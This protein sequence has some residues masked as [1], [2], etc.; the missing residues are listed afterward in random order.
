MPT[1]LW[2]FLILIGIVVIVFAIFKRPLY[3]AML[4]SFVCLLAS[5]GM[6]NEAPHYLLSSAQNSL[7]FTIVMFLVFSSILKETGVIQDCIDIIMALVGRIPGG[8]GVVAIVSS[9]FMGAMS[10]SG[11]GNVAATGSVTI[12]LMKKAGYPAEFAAGIAM[13]G[14]CLGPVIPPSATIIAAFS[15]LSVVDGLEGF[16]FSSFW[17]VMYSVSLVFILHRL[18]QFYIMYAAL[19]IK[20]ADASELP[21]LKESW[22]R[23]W[24]SF[25]LVVVIMLPFALDNFFGDWFASVIG[26]TAADYLSDSVLVFT[27]AI[28]SAYSLLVSHKRRRRSLGELAKAVSSDMKS[29]VSMCMVLFFAYAISELLTD[30]GTITAA[31][32]F[33][34]SLNLSFGGMTFVL[35]VVMT[36][37]GMFMSGTSLIPLLGPVYVSILSGYGADPIVIA[38]IIPVLFVSLGQMTPPFALA[39]MAA[40]GIAQS[41]FRKTSVH[42]IIW[43]V[44]QFILVYLIIIGVIPISIPQW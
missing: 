27:P 34:D 33:L 37:L 18:I 15:C 23:G 25:L 12:P 7:L 19:G 29:I 35:L 42:A 32:E 40:M 24:P 16:Q 41:D 21:G 10:G 4:L 26:D 38:A 31:E 3:E 11:P 30:C 36:I 17:M 13:S 5:T 2:N 6:W 43:S 28:A 14:S 9:A 20:R 8:A 39:M 44:V 22:R 1:Q